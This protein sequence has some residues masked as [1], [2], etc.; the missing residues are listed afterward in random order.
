V[1]DIVSDQDYEV[2]A[3]IRDASNQVV[4]IVYVVWRLS[5]YKPKTE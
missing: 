5:P 3:S 2:K 4:A 1:P